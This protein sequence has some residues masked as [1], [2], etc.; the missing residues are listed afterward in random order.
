MGSPVLCES[1]MLLVLNPFE[2]I[3]GYENVDMRGVF[4]FCLI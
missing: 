2:Q 3:L 4:G 1:F